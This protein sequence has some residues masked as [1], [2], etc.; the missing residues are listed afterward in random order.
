VV[1]PAQDAGVAGHVLVAEDN[2]VNQLVL[3][4]MLHN[5]GCSVDLVADG[6]AAIEAAGARRYDLVFMDCHMP[7]TDGY[8]A[9]RGIRARERVAGAASV[10]IVALTAAALAADRDQCFAAGMDDFLSKPVS[11]PLLG[12]MLRRW[13]GK[14]SAPQPR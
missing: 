12:A 1:A 2:A 11:M 3:Q 7:G 6:A 8:A 4:A 10:P 5:L 13:V 14:A 9:T